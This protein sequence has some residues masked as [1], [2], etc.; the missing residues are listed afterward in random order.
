MSKNKAPKLRYVV[1]WGV[2]IAAFIV[3]ETLALL[4]RDPGPDTA[5]ELIW[6][7]VAIP[8]LWWVAAG[9]LF[10]LSIHFLFRGRYD[11]PRDWFRDRDN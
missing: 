7:I 10:W 1:A 3:I 6:E 5:S 11:D 9:F 8:V 4:N 2:W